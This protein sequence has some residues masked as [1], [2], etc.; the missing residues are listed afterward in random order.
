MTLTMPA[1]TPTHTP[2]AGGSTAPTGSAGAGTTMKAVAA[3]TY[4]PPEALRLEDVA[5]PTLDDD[6]VLVRVRASSV[7]PAEWYTVTGGIAAVRL[8]SGSPLKPKNPFPGVDFAGV[9]EA[10]GST[11]TQFKPGDEVLGAR[12]GAWAEYVHVKASRNI[13]HKPANVTFEQ[14]ASVGIAGCTAIQGLRDH[15]Q[16]QPGQKVLVNGASG[17]VGTFAI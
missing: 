5:I 8:L 7:N 17:G 10:V 6:G 11:V 13:V 1:T 3:R 4:G 14:A 15:G 9:V 16:L 12:N 2:A